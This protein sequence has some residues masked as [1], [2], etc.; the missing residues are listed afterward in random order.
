M[1]TQRESGLG[2]RLTAGAVPSPGR[3][4]WRFLGDRLPSLDGEMAGMFQS[5]LERAPRALIGI[6]NPHGNTVRLTNALKTP[7]HRS[8]QV[9][10]SGRR[11]AKPRRAEIRT[12]F[13]QSSHVNA[14]PPDRR[15]KH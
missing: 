12:L 13:S 10:L 6:D 9:S 4:L 14:T 15:A 11:V 2:A 5:E 3:P 1:L 8:S 7:S